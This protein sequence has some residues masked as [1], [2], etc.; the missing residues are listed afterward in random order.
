MMSR[1][2]VPKLIPVRPLKQKWYEFLITYGIFNLYF[3]L[4]N[5]IVIER[6]KM[7]LSKVY[8]TNF[9]FD[10]S[11]FSI[12]LN[13]ILSPVFL[14][15]IFIG[16]MFFMT[17]V[18]VA[19]LGFKYYYFKTMVEAEQKRKLYRYVKFTIALFALLNFAVMMLLYEGTRTVF[20]ALLYLPVAITSYI[21]IGLRVKSNR[22]N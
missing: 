5:D 13:I 2:P 21:V 7:K 8:V 4:L 11:D 14:V 9:S 12:L 10:G 19:F 15:I 16:I 20:S 1:L 3:L 22:I 17:N 18:I 6:I